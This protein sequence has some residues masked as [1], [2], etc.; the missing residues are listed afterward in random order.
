MFTA[1]TAWAV[2]GHGLVQPDRLGP[3]ASFIQSVIKQSYSAVRM[4]VQFEWGMLDYIY[5]YI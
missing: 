4:I 2:P 1:G 3:T 5:V